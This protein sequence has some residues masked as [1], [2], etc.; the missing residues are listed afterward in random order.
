[1]IFQDP[2]VKNVIKL[3]SFIFNS[4][5]A[6]SLILSLFIVISTVLAFGT[7]FTPLFQFPLMINRY[8]SISGTTKSGLRSFIVLERI[9]Y[10]SYPIHKNDQ[11]LALQAHFCIYQ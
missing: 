2:Q 9:L 1:M 6:K 11:L 4:F 5:E 7:I 8:G 10:Y 3:S